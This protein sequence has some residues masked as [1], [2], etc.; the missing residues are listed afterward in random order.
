MR[1]CGG[2]KSPPRRPEVNVN[3]ILPTQ[4]RPKSPVVNISLKSDVSDL[5]DSCTL[6]QK[7]FLAC[8]LKIC[9]PGVFPIL[10]DYREKRKNSTK[11]RSYC[12]TSNPQRMIRAVLLD[13]RSFGETKLEL[14]RCLA[15]SFED[16]E[17]NLTKYLLPTME[18]P[19]VEVEV[20]EDSIVFSLVIKKHSL[21][22]TNDSH[23]LKKARSQR[24]PV[25][26]AELTMGEGEEA[27]AEQRASCSQ[28]TCHMVTLP[29]GN[30]VAAASL[31]EV[32]EAEEVEVGE[33][34]INNNLLDNHLCSFAVTG[35]T[36]A[37]QLRFYCNNCGIS[38][39][40]RLAVLLG[41]E[42]DK[43]EEEEEVAEEV[44]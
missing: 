24:G 19:D 38:I 35:R 1:S 44:E 25:S 15:L 37:L 16:D 30:D 41:E 5:L 2:A 18:V 13:A 7:W 22:A 43:V 8:Q 9:F 20:D 31:Q 14:P 29:D 3:N 42:P 21:K 6:F 4:T 12:C 32:P 17:G 39:C 10:F 27:G 40:K 33:K 36:P 34:E 11:I 28:K 26:E 23:Q